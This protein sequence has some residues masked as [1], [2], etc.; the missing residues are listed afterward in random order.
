M[1]EFWK[2][3]HICQSY[4]NISH[5]I[6]TR[7]YYARRLFFAVGW[8]N[9]SYL[10]THQLLLKSF[11]R[12]ASGLRRCDKHTPPLIPVSV[13]FA[14]VVQVSWLMRRQ[15][16]YYTTC[17]SSSRVGQRSGHRPGNKTLLWVVTGCDEYSFDVDQVGDV[18]RT[19]SV[20]A[21]SITAG[22]GD[23]VT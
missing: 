6:R 14:W 20:W 5:I 17:Y 2:L 23:I 11:Q 7:V 19:V 22:K 8:E 3:V 12:R 16:G 21:F 18:D 10:Y 4:H 15:S 13:S 9:T 1:N